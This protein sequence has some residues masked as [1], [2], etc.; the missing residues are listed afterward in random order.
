M[1]LLFSF[2]QKPRLDMAGSSLIG[3]GEL[4]QRVVQDPRDWK[5]ESWRWDG[6]KKTQWRAIKLH[7]HLPWLT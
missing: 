1:F 5:N 2:V 3:Q 6:G 7:L 4:G